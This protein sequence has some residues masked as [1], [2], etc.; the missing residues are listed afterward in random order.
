MHG[1][2]QQTTSKPEAQNRSIS[3]SVGGPKS[4]KKAHGKKQEE[5]LEA[6]QDKSI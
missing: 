2:L 6:S 1:Y 5:Y 3:F 4:T